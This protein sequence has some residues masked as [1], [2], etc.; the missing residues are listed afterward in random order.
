M[1]TTSVPILV[2]LGLSVL[3]LGPMYVTDR[4][5]SDLRQTSDVH[6]HY[7]RRHHQILLWHPST[8]AQEHLTT[9]ITIKRRN[10]KYIKMKKSVRQRLVEQLRDEG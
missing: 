7:H 4:Q 3:D 6:H 9:Q 1:W 5:M 10:I 2:F 8:G